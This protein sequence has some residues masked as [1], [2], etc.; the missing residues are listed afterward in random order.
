[1]A[2]YSVNKINYKE[3]SFDERI[4]DSFYEE[5]YD[6]IYNYVYFKTGDRANAE[7]LACH[8]IEKIL[9]N[10]H[11][12]NAAASS[13]NTWIFTIAK[14]HLIDYFR[15]KRRTECHFEDGEE[16]LI[17]DQVTAGPDE[18]V[19]QVEQEEQIRSLLQQLP[20]TEREIII[21]KFWSGL[22]NIEIAEQLELNSNNVNVMVFRALQKLKKIIEKDRIEL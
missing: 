13:L 2:D 7:D 12:Y 17:A 22:K 21:F 11:K 9:N 5:Y 6:K 8:I 1:M 14:N 16:F 20:E 19:M 3:P 15:L 4:F 18:T 10:M